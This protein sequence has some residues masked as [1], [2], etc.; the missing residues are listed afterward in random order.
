MFFHLVSCCLGLSLIHPP[1]IRKD[2]MEVSDVP[3]RSLNVSVSMYQNIATTTFELRYFNNMDQPLHEADLVFPYDTS[4]AIADVSMRVDDKVFVSYALESDAAQDEY[5]KKKDENFTALLVKKVHDFL[6]I[7][8][9]TIPPKKEVTVAFTASSVIPTMFSASKE[10][11]FSHYVL[12]M[13]FVPRYRPRHHDLGEATGPTAG[14]PTSQYSFSFAFSAPHATFVECPSY[15]SALVDQENKRISFTGNISCDLIVDA[16]HPAV[17]QS[18]SETYGNTQV[19]Q[20]MIEGRSYPVDEVQKEKSIVFL[21]D[22]SGSMGYGD[23]SHIGHLRQAMSTIIHSLHLGVSFD[24]VG[25]G[26]TW[27]SLFGKL[28]P[29]NDDTMAEA[30]KYIDQIA[31]DYGGTE[32]MQ[33]LQAILN[34]MKP[35]IVILITDG[36][37]SNTGEILDFVRNHTTMISTLGIGNAASVDLVRGIADETGGVHEFV[38]NG[39]KIEETVVRF[40]Q[41]SLNPALNSVTVAVSG[42]Q[43]VGRVPKTL[44]RNQLMSVRVLSPKSG[45]PSLT[46]NGVSA[47]GVPFS[48]QFTTNPIQISGKALHSILVLS[49]INGRTL[50]QATA[51]EMAKAL[52]LMTKYTSLVLYDNTVKYEDVA[53]TTVHIPV[54]TFSHSRVMFDCAGG[55]PHLSYAKSAMNNFFSFTAAGARPAK[56]FES[57]DTVEMEAVTESTDANEQNTKTIQQLTKMQKANGSWTSLKDVLKVLNFDSVSSTWTDEQTAT[58]LALEYL[59]QDP[60]KVEIVKKATKWLESNMTQEDIKCLLDWAKSFLAQV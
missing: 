5:N 24:I 25:F 27:K 19:T 46:I 30:E 3:L 43:I 40:L 49:G 2:H 58:A 12:P 37:V 13:T 35:D 17:M 47:T 34:D 38:D 39:A 57:V 21:L 33:P 4:M 55:A 56:S 44:T 59:K 31:A 42:G 41:D 52:N 60:N 20:F 53:N 48:E 36:A 54:P 45:R 23:N 32:V 14:G 18:I 10:R 7:S 6:E 1:M 28:V 15:P 51:T 9:A 26:S 29:Y 16:Y 50:E 8:L 11:W 22:R